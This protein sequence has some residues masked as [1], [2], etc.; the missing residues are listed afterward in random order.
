MSARR[1]L[2]ALARWFADVLADVLMVSL[3]VL[4]GALLLAWWAGV[5]TF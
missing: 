4:A 1:L 3:G 2:A 5:L